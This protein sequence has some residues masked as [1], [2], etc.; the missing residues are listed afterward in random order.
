MTS[1]QLA[2]RGVERAL[3]GKRRRYE[4]EF[5]R[6][7]DAAVHVM[8]DRDTANPSV[9]EI[10]TESGL[11]TTAFY[12]HFPTKDDLLVTL[13]EHA[14]EVTR[15]HLEQ[16]LATR[17]DP[18]ERIVEWVR[19]M[20]DL[21]RTDV[22]IRTNRPFLLAHP[23]LLER[24]PEEIGAGFDALTVPLSTAIRDARTANSLPSDSAVIDARLAMHHVFGILIDQAALR[25]RSDRSTVDAVISYTL[26]AV[27]HTDAHPC[28]T[29]GQAAAGKPEPRGRSTH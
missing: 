4:E 3:A 6:L 16:R 17:E 10:L 22:L 15:Q 18:V 2:P 25:R 5:A 27:L 13:L 23:R 29:R 14:H 28:A 1:S 24:F 26:R 20:F 8:R 21:L 12:R 19:G 9:A 7:L 11:S